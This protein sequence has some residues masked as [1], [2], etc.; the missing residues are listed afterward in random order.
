[1]EPELTYI[2]YDTWKFEQYM[3]IPEMLLVRN[4]LKMAIMDIFLAEF[5]KVFGIDARLRPMKDPEHPSMKIYDIFDKTCK[6]LFVVAAR[7]EYDDDG[8]F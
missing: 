3:S 8:I 6:S 5:H 1:M 7:P 2:R 4:N